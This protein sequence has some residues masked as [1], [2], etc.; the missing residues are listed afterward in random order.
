MDK[1]VGNML[2]NHGKTSWQPEGL[3]IGK[4][5]TRA[6]HVPFTHSPTPTYPQF[7]GRIA[8]Q[9]NTYFMFNNRYLKSSPQSLTLSTSS[10]VKRKTFLLNTVGE[11]PTFGG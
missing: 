2:A 9:I 7:R 3:P 8:G 6:D 5:W 10:T 1:G 11:S 4:P